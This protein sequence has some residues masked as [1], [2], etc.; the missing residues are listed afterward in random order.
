MAHGDDPLQF[1]LSSSVRSDVLRSVAD[2]SRATDV[3]L[4]TVDA[5][6]SAVY[7][8]LGRLEEADM[9]QSDDD[10]WSLTGSGRVIADCVEERERLDV[11][12][13]DA[14]CYLASHDTCAIPERFR[15]RISELAGGHVIR[16]SDIEPHGVVREVTDRLSAADMAHVITPV[17]DEL[18]EAV[19]PESENSR[20]LVDPDVVAS[21]ADELD[22]DAEILAGLEHY[23]EYDVRVTPVDFAMSV[24]D[25]ALMLSLPPLDGGYDSQTE[26][27]AEDERARQW[28]LDLFEELWATAR[29]L[30]TYV[31]DR[32]L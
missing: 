4:D 27:I 2:G 14:G 21:V 10:A 22:D 12:L 20:V 24:T 29:P 25:S 7:D 28:G 9:L 8:A 15:L 30:E 18:F 3:L 23:D 6:S 1:V 17:Y 16:A 26:F 13:A 11:L 19:M 5:S 31:S 32:L